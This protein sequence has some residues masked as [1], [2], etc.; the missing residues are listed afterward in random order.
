MGRGRG[1]SGLGVSRGSRETARVWHKTRRPLSQVVTFGQ[2][3][4]HKMGLIVQPQTS[5]VPQ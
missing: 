4:H 1:A 2:G 3:F 5:L